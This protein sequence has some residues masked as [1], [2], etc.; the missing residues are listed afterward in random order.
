MEGRN[1]KHND[2]REV[3]EQRKAEKAKQRQRQQQR[4]FKQS[5]SN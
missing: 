4:Q 2:R 5:Q 3:A 1:M